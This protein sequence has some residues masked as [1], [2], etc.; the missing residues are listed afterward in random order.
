MVA[1]RARQAE[2][3]FTYVG[4]VIFVAILGL[5]GA[6]TL[7]VDS[8]L[9]RAAAEQE[10]LEIGAEYSEALRSYAAATPRGYPTAPPT[11]QELLK[12]PRFPGTRRHLRRI[13]V[14][15]VTGR[16]E[17]GIVYQGDKVGVLAVYSLSQAQP[18]KVAN[19]DARFQNFE[20][21]EHLSE[22]KFTA[23]GTG[24]S[25][26]PGANGQPPNLQPQ[27]NV[28]PAPLFPAPGTEPPPPTVPPP[29]QPTE[30]PQP[31]EPPETQTESE[32]EPAKEPEEPPAQ[33]QPAEAEAEPAPAEPP[34]A[35]PPGNGRADGR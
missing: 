9:R 23:S 5:V 3:G 21:K 35:E 30:P 14:D 15:P 28:Q 29:R 11:L 18:L 2:G 16:Q 24:A 20:N 34:P 4:L 8:L 17:W 32:A 1:R 33:P 27:P 19:F 31:A 13:Y 25:A 22:W 6:A 10:L 7:K 26:A 12:D